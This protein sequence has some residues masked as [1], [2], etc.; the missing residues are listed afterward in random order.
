[1]DSLPLFC[2]P[3]DSL[4]RFA[5]TICSVNFLAGFPSRIRS[6]DSLAIFARCTH[7]GF[8]PLFSHWIRSKF[9]LPSILSS[10]LSGFSCWSRL[11]FSLR[12]R[13]LD[14]LWIRSLYSLAGFALDSLLHSLLYSLQFSRWSRL[15]YSLCIHLLDSLVALD[16]LADGSTRFTR[17]ICSL[18]L[19]VGGACWNRLQDSLA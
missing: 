12:I 6:L 17:W 13:S 5:G 10:I 11:L 1:V 14:S 2:L 8:S 7:S 19:R 3:L 4:A 9:S 16:S 15:L 18:D